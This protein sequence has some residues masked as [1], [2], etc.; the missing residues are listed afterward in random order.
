MDVIARLHD[1]AGQAA[2]AV[3]ADTQVKMADAS[4]LKQSQ[5]VQ[6]YGY[7]F[8]DTNGPNLVRH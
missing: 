8:R 1:C 5:G 2:D 7:V 6:T 4:K 3:A